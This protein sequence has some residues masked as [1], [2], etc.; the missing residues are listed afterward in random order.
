MNVDDKKEEIYFEHYNPEELQKVIDTQT[1]VISYMKNHK[2]KQLHSILI[3]V[4]DHA[5]DLNFVRHS[6]FLHALATR[7]RHQAISFILSAQK[8]RSLA[9][10]IRLNASSLYIFRLKNQTELDAFIEESSALVD[11]KTLLEMYKVAVKEP[12]SFFYININGK[13]INRTFYIRF[14]KAFQLE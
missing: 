8:Y 13:D 4:D 2:L 11:K 7:G 6:K 14:E 1:K 9:N 5:D 12:Y 3:V 10:I